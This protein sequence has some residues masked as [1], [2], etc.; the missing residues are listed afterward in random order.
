MAIFVVI[1]TD[2]SN[3]FNS[4]LVQFH[5]FLSGA[6]ISKTFPENFL[7]FEPFEKCLLAAGNS[8]QKLLEFLRVFISHNHNLAWFAFIPTISNNAITFFNLKIKGLS[9]PIFF[10]VFLFA[11]PENCQVM[12]SCFEG[13][14]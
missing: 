3:G 6:A 5:P 1:L 11:S 4:H 2:N 9:I 10:P 12:H 8:C 13:S 7:G 14:S